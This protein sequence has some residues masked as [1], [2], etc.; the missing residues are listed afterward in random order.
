MYIAI[1]STTVETGSPEQEL[2]A[3]LDLLGPVLEK[4]VDVVPTYKPKTDGKEERVF[5]SKSYDA[6]SHFESTTADVMDVYE[7]ITGHPLDLTKKRRDH[8]EQEQ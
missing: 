3:G 8:T 6:T 7:R 4:V 2:K 5:I 1:V